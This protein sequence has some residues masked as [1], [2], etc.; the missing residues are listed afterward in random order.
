MSSTQ[1]PNPIQKIKL[2]TP[3]QLLMELFGHIGKKTF[4]VSDEDSIRFMFQYLKNPPFTLHNRV[5][6]R[7]SHDEYLALD[8][9]ME[10]I[11]T[12]FMEHKPL[13][14]ESADLRDEAQTANPG[15]DRG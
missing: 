12:Y 7:M 15:S 10:K 5:A 14:P 2:S 11:S 13:E 6:M 4:I 9:T 3:E 8:R 1:H